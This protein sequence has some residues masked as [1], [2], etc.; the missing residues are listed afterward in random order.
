MYSV[1]IPTLWRSTR[2]LRLISDLV[3]CSRVGEV[4][5]IDNN[6]GQI[7]EGGKVKIISNG[8]NNY[9]NPSWNMGV[10][11]DTYPFIAL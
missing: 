8:K 10:Y 3:Q 1:I 11:A 6:N 7:A 2:T 5:I 4:I 9:V